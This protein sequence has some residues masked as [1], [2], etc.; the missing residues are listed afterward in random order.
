MSTWRIGGIDSGVTGQSVIGLGEKV[1]VIGQ[2]LGGHLALLFADFF[3]I[4][5]IK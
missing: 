3:L 1:N 5:S 4:V 2:S